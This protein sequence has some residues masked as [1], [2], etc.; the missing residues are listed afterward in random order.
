MGKIKKSKTA[1]SKIPFAVLRKG[2]LCAVLGVSLLAGGGLLAGCTNAEVTPGKDGATWLTGAIA[3]T[4]TKGKDGDLYL[5][6]ATNKIYLKAGGVWSEI[7]TFKG[8]KG[9][10]GVP[11]KPKVPI[12]VWIAGEDYD[13][14]PESLNGG[15]EIIG[16]K[17][18]EL[19][20]VKYQEGHLIILENAHVYIL[21]VDKNDFNLKPKFLLALHSYNSGD[22]V[23]G[24]H[25]YVHFAYANSPDGV[26]DFITD[27]EI[28]NNN[29]GNE[30]VSTFS[31]RR[32]SNNISAVDMLYMG[33]YSDKTKDPITG[34]YQT[35]QI[36]WQYRERDFLTKLC[37]EYQK[38][39]TAIR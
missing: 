25:G 36:K 18:D 19:T 31:L 10:P 26:E 16:W 4:N 5:D 3:P 7:G 14:E 34:K 30:P 2:A 35:A 39:A 20:D 15:Y 38:K 27:D 24:K 8:D 29:Y 6:T 17:D 32:S 12:H 23:N 9:D 28:R 33:I 37:K 11:T 13:A 21:E 22:I 1:K